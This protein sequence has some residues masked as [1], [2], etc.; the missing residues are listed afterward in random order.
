MNKTKFLKGACQQCGGRLEFPAEM[1]GLAAPCP[2]CGQR[3]DLLLAP[4]PETPALPRKT[5][6]WTSVA[7][8]LLVLGLAG[9]MVALKRAEGWALRH[10]KPAA[11][12]TNSSAATP[13]GELAGVNQNGFA[14]SGIKFEKTPGSALVYAVGTLKNLT[15]RQRFGVKVELDLFDAADQKVGTAK[16]YQRVLEAGADWQFKALVVETKAVSAKV[17]AINEEQ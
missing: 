11:A 16:D 2:H 5:L 3:T 13:V 17:A 12:Q 14:V 1:A 8:L 7:V 10:K 9:A 6:V 4:P 15:N